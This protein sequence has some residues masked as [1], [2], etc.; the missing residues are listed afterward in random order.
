MAHLVDLVHQKSKSRVVAVLLTNEMTR[1]DRGTGQR[2]NLDQGCRELAVF[3]PGAKQERDGSI[4]HNL[5]HDVFLRHMAQLQEL[6]AVRGYKHSLPASLAAK[7]PVAIA[8]SG[9]YRSFCGG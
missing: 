3:V 8:H 4:G 7:H 6:V 5:G 2:H 9:G 1:H